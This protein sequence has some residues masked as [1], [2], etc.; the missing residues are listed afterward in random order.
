MKAK[1]HKE[2][3]LKITFSNTNGLT[4]R[5]DIL[6]DSKSY[7]SAPFHA[8]GDNGMG[9]VYIPVLAEKNTDFKV[10]LNLSGYTLTVHS[11]ELVEI[12]DRWQP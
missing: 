7:A 9:V 6:I 1:E 8:T 3:Y 4:V 5:S 12:T 11:A 2:Y 10:R